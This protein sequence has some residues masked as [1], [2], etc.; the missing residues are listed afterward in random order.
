MDSLRGSLTPH[1]S[2]RGVLGGRQRINGLLREGGGTTNYEELENLPAFNGITVEG[3]HDG[4]YYGLANLSDIP[5]VIDY[6]FDEQNTGVKWLDGKDIYQKVFEIDYPSGSGY[7]LIDSDVLNYVD[8]VVSITGC[9]DY[10]SFGQNYQYN[11]PYCDGSSTAMFT[12]DYTGLFFRV[13]NDN[14][15]GYKIYCVLRYTK[16]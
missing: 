9:A 12:F 3:D 1:A 14:F 5:N 13:V 4:H 6:S 2:L 10:R 15:S 8:T 7:H 16:L 11:I